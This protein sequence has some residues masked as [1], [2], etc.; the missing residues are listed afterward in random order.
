MDMEI[1]K[2]AVFVDDDKFVNMYHKQLT[3]KVG[4]AKEVHFFEDAEEALSYLKGIQSEEE[5]PELILVDINMPKIDGH[6]FVKTV[7]QLDN[8][9][10][11]QVMMAFLTNSKDIKDVIKA[12]ED[13][14][15]YYYWKPLNFKL[16]DKLLYD[17]FSLRLM[18]EYG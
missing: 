8:Y 13:K 3:S 17:G 1:L 6:Q 11:N 5:F 15:N 18:E 10:P 16:I 14:V 9:N 7:N 2:K 4:L 12:D